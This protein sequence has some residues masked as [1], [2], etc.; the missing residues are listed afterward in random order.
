MCQYSY[1]FLEGE[2]KEEGGEGGGYV[3]LHVRGHSVIP[4]SIYL[5]SIAGTTML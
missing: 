3:V 5:A 4:T 2:A 1:H